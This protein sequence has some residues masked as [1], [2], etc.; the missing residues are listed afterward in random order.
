MELLVQQNMEIVVRT[1][2]WA[3]FNPKQYSPEVDIN[4]L[5]QHSSVNHM[6]EHGIIRFD[7]CWKLAQSTSYSF[8]HVL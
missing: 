1:C 8:Q 2:L 4:G 3:C 7:Q 6:Y 5:F